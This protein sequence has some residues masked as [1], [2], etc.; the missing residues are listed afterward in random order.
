MLKRFTSVALLALLSGCST[1]SGQWSEKVEVEPTVPAASE[2][3]SLPAETSERQAL[4]ALPEVDI[5][6]VKGQTQTRFDDALAFMQAGDWAAAEVLLEKVTEQQPELAGP[7]ANLG[8]VRERLGQSGEAEFSKALEAN[9]ANCYVRNHLGVAARKQGDF[10]KAEEHY[11]ACLATY[12]NHAPVRLNLGILYELYM[13]RYSEALAAYQDYQL[14]L[15]E[16][17]P[18]V[19]GWLVDLERRVAAYAQR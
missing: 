2:A 19:N 1:M 11:L 10:A 17:D 4:A 14:V 13:G 3:T 18:K 12:P 8:I 7:W 9:P 6:E 15:D 16:P 5:P